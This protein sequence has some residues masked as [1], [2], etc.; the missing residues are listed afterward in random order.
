MTTYGMISTYP[1]TRC[2]LA[3]FAERL[4][5]GLLADHAEEVRV[6]R[7]GEPPHDGDPAEVV[8]R[9]V[10]GGTDAKQAAEALNGC[11][12][13][14]VQH[15]F[16]IYGGADGQDVLNVAELLAVPTIAVLHTVPRV[17]TVHQRDVLEELADQARAVTVMSQADADRL[18]TDYAV[19]AAKV[20]LIEIT[21][22]AAVSAAYGR[23]ASLLL[24]DQA[25]LVA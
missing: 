8:A 24:S 21:D 18:L 23:L 10:V 6:V 14:V 17:P 1:P 4:R 13:A 7:V 11:D 16:G 3:N 5:A 2:G 9:F 22:W 20:A 19:D 12:V 15:E 25:Q